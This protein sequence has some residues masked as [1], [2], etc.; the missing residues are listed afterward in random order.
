MC[1]VCTVRVYGAGAPRTG[2]S[3][4]NPRGGGGPTPLGPVPTGPPSWLMFFRLRDPDTR[5]FIYYPHNIILYDIIR[6]AVVRRGNRSRKSF[7][8]STVVKCKTGVICNGSSTYPLPQIL[9]LAHC[10][11]DSVRLKKRYPTHSLY[12]VYNI[13]YKCDSVRILKCNFFIWIH[14]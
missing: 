7:F 14:E 1:S 4:E 6:V 11:A 5:C 9:Y 2:F 3:L 8:L 13:I 10:I 12:A